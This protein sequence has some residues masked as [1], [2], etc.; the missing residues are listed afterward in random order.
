MRLKQKVAIVTGAAS[1]LGAAAARKMAAEGAQVLLVDRDGERGEGVAAA[2]RES[3]GTAEFL[4][5]DMGELAA[6]DA[7]V[8]RAVERFGALHVL[9]NNT[10]GAVPRKLLDLEPEQWD[11]S[12][13]LG[14]R[15]YWYA[16]KCA[17]PHMLQAGGGAIV[18]TASIS[19]LAADHAL[20][21]YNVTKAAI[22]NL[23]RSIALDH[24]R[25]NIRCNA[26]CPGIVFTPPFEPVQAKHPQLIEAM[27]AGVPM[28]R[29]GRAEEIAAAVAFLASDEASFITGAAL[30]ADGGQTA[31]TGTP[32][33]QSTITT[34]A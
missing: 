10:A 5:G 18:N 1:G 8:A 29:F 24:A 7:M 23:T 2:I 15:P 16:S 21:V 27:A 20:G 22:I 30:V 33:F 25:D 13:V 6:M 4:L 26:V 14:L 34:P 11:T 28:G 9:H 32:S 19:G 17:I 12:M 31:Y 3:G